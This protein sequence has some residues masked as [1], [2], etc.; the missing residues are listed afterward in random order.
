MT[1]YYKDLEV[2]EYYKTERQ[3]K[4][5]DIE[6]SLAELWNFRTKAKWTAGIQYEL[7]SIEKYYKAELFDLRDVK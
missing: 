2:D 3:R 6:Q 5:Q 1:D 7:N 4:K